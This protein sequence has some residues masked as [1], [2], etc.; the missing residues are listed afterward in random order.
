MKNKLIFYKWKDI[1]CLYKG[2]GYDG[3]IW[4]WN[5]CYFNSE[6]IFN[7]I[8]SSGCMGCKTLEDFIREKKSWTD[9]DYTIYDLKDI[10][11]I[12]NFTKDNNA[13]LVLLICEALE[14][15]EY[16]IN[17]EC[18]DCH[19]SYSVSEILGFGIQPQGGIVYTHEK[20]ICYDCSHNY[21]IECKSPLNDDNIPEELIEEFP[22]LESKEHCKNC[23]IMAT[24][25]EVERI[26]KILNNTK[27]KFGDNRQINSI[28]DLEYKIDLINK[29]QSL[30]E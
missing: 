7:D 4:E 29:L 19:N 15:S 26:K 23:F 9:E 30:E 12:K 6:G 11:Q 10:Q 13:S 17:I 20:L 22:E 2:G 5:A 1:L 18:E 16:Q 24:N 28:K 25:F 8:F 21:C 14:D 27:L 3:C